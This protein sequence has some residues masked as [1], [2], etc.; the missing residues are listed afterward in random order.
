MK[1]V[2]IQQKIKCI[3]GCAFALIIIL[4]VCSVIYLGCNN[5]SNP[6]VNSL[7]LIGSYVGAIATLAAAYIASLLFND[8]K[9][10]SRF[11]IKKETLVAL[12]KFKSH[13]DKNHNTSKYLLESYFLQ[14]QSPPLNAEYIAARI[15]EAKNSIQKKEEYIL[16]LNN[17]L[18]SLFEKIDIYE[19]ILNENLITES[20]RQRNFKLYPSFISGMYTQAYKG[21]LKKIKNS[22]Q[23]ADGCKQIFEN[24]VYNGV[25]T[26]L[27]NDLYLK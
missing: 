22:Y 7:T 4:I 24:N 1:V 18:T 23:L 8:W 25:L 2:D 26:K 20:D 6:I 11:D 3:V 16:E 9:S 19:A 10:V 14:E 12:L 21:D 27:K 13:I 15:S 17:L 5:D